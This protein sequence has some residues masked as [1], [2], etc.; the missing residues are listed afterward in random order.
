MKTFL[1]VY[2]AKITLENRA[3]L[4]CKGGHCT[5]ESFDM[6]TSAACEI[7]NFSFAGT[8]RELTK[9]RDTAQ[10]SQPASALHQELK[11]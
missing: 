8:V 6:E 10:T 4:V 7:G 3:K 2:F 1:D 5:K 11:M 9:Y